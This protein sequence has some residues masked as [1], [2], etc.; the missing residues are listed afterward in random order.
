VIIIAIVLN[1]IAS[2]IANLTLPAPVRGF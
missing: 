1:F 2:V